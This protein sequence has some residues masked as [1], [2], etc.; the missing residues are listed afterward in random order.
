MCCKAARVHRTQDTQDV[1]ERHRVTTR[2]AH[3]H[4][5]LNDVG[6]EGPAAPDQVAQGV[7]G[8]LHGHRLGRGVEDLAEVGR[9]VGG[10]GSI[11]AKQLHWA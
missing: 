10:L 5:C 9:E 1:L 11:L 6:C 7:G 3:G 8:H 4:L 2:E